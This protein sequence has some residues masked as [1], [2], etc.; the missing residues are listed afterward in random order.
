MSWIFCAAL[1]E[2]FTGFSLQRREQS[3]TTIQVRQKKQIKSDE[4]IDKDGEKS[5]GYR[6][7]MVT[8]RRRVEAR[9]VDPVT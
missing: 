3:R 9:R 2:T 4:K 1:V 7:R 8:D 5:K 6:R